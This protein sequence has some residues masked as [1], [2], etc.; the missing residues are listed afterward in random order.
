MFCCSNETADRIAAYI[1]DN[2]FFSV[3][4]LT[5]DYSVRK[6]P[7][8]VDC[9]SNLESI[10][11]PCC[12]KKLDFAWWGKAMDIAYKHKFRQRE[13][14]LPCCGKSSSLD[15]LNYYYDCGF[16]RV[17][18]DLWNPVAIPDND[19]IRMIEKMLGTTVKIIEAH[20]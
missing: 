4:R 16:S 10:T 15:S 9:A 12:G 20:L 13:I 2:V 1:R 3:Q 17:E 6:D 5:V 19:C 11:C 7:S 18:F 8:F 14:V